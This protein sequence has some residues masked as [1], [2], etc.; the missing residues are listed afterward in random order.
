MIDEKEKLPEHYRLN[1]KHHRRI[2]TKEARE[3]F[4]NMSKHVVYTLGNESAI[5]KV[6]EILSL[7]GFSPENI[8]ISIHLPFSE[9]DRI[10]SGA[11]SKFNHTN[12]KELKDFFCE[13]G[14]KLLTAENKSATKIESC[15]L[16]YAN[17][18][19]MVIFPYNIPTM[20]VTALWC[21]GSVDGIPWIPLAERRRRGGKDGKYLGED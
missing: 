19:A 14:E 9:K 18:E 17:A 21:K 12:K 1:E 15:R 4:K 6:K 20:T 11:E 8:H 7:I 10:F 3:K 16:G 13:V 5:G 2:S